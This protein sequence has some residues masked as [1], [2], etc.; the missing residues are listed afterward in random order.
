MKNNSN[1]DHLS[2]FWFIVSNMIPPVGFFIYFKNRN[3]FPKK[4]RKA[5]ISALTGIPIAIAAGYVMNNYILN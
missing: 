1:E 2:K 4:A 3:E 5:L